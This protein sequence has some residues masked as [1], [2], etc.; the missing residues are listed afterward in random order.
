MKFLLLA[1][2]IFTTSTFANNLSLDTLTFSADSQVARKIAKCEVI[3]EQMHGVSEL[4]GKFK[5]H[6]LLKM[7][8]EGMEKKLTSNQLTEYM[9]GYEYNK[10]YWRG[11]FDAMS[12]STK[13][14]SSQILTAL[15]KESKCSDYINAS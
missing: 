7:V 15:Y 9:F 14:A 4:S 8:D 3:H 11:W 10:N 12:I 5:I 2:S 6:A 1:L 13:E